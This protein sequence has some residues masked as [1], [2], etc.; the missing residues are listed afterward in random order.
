[1]QR[2][3]P[4]FPI[5]SITSKGQSPPDSVAAGVTTKTKSPPIQNKNTRLV[6]HVEFPQDFFD[7]IYV[8][9]CIFM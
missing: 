4:H 7:L 5:E 6:G 3:S 8:V 9:H 2:S 1:M